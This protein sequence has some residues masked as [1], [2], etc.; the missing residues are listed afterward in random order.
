MS[1]SPP[2]S[3]DRRSFLRLSA[4][5]GGGL[6]LG[7]WLPSAAGAGGPEAAEKESGAPDGPFA[8]NAYLRIST[9]GAITIISSRPE[10]GQGIRTSLPMVVAEELEVDWQAVTVVSAPIDGSVYG[11]QGAGGSTSTPTSYLDMRRAGAVARTLLVAAAA[12]RWAVAE[13][14]CRAENATVL[15]LGGAERLTYGELAAAA[16]AL[17]VPDPKSVALKD[18]KDFKI[19]GRRIGGVDNPK[20][21]TGRRLFGID[22]KVPGMFHAVFEK[23]PVFGCTV[24]DAN[25]DHVK[26]LRGVHDAFVI[27]GTDNL[28]GLMPGVA[29]VA[30]STWSAFSAR[31]AAAG[32]GLER[33]SPQQGQLEEVHHDRPRALGAAGGDRPPGRRRRGGRPR[34]S[35]Q[36][37]RGGLYPPFHFPCQPRASE[38]HCPRPRR[39]GGTLGADA[40]RKFR[41]GSGC[42]DARDT[43]REGD[44]AQHPGRRRIRPAAERRL[45]A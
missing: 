16:A 12:R 35:L 21:V 26:S 14:Q 19:L 37:R 32:G 39:R 2:G 28:T 40:E 13:G 17:P 20:L 27:D 7:F 30:D 29:I 45:H 36:G 15:H 6:M 1:A 11:W 10:I 4:L 38:L 43:P 42:E 25:L 22:Q 5:G 23:C 9:D 24:D 34:R 8:P 33:R 18:P 44:R 41:T 31:A 3:I